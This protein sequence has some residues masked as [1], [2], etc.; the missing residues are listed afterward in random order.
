MQSDVHGACETEYTLVKAKE[1]SLVLRK[2][3]QMNTCSTRYKQHSVIQTTP[4]QF[5]SVSRKIHLP[6]ESNA[7]GTICE[8]SRLHTHRRFS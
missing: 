5:P 6:E 7:T 1:T 3:K 4:Y 8:S 2:V